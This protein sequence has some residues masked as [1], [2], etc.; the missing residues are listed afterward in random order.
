M[1][2]SA[3]NQNTAKLI[4]GKR[5]YSKETQLK[6]IS[7]LLSVNILLNRTKVISYKNVVEGKFQKTQFNKKLLSGLLITSCTD[8]ILLNIQELVNL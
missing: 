1:F 7:G 5:N 6:L 3:R 4:G 8:L 2:D